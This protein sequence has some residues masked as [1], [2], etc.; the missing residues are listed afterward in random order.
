MNTN[1]VILHRLKGQFYDNILRIRL[2]WA[3]KIVMIKMKKIF[4]HFLAH[5][6]CLEGFEFYSFAEEALAMLAFLI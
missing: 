6:K 1:V 2:I 4:R 3:I 5:T